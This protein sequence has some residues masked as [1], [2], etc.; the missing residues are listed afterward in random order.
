MTRTIARYWRVAATGIS[1]FVFGLAGLVLGFLV[2]PVMRML[3]ADDR[4][5][6]ARS[7]DLLRY[8]FRGFIALMS[9]LGVIR[10]SV[11]GLERLDRR[12]LLITSNHPSLID[13]VLL[14]AFIHNADCVVDAG[15]VRNRYTRG[16]IQAAGYIPN[17]PAGLPLVEACVASLE[18][19]GN[20]LF[21]A[22]ARRTTPGEPIR[23]T[24]G[25]AQVAVRGSRD[26]TPVTIQCV[27]PHLTR[28]AKW[29][30]VPVRR[31][32]YTITVHEEIAI[33]PF[34][35]AFPEPALSAR[36]LTDHLQLYFS[37]EIPTHAVA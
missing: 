4:R 28:G 31:P 20:V 23:L 2:F 34:L 11:N 10:Y 18:Q 17:Q 32:Q 12:G 3:M 26:V 9:G 22:E 13:A 25:A 16:A 19:G 5:R 1:F 24:R 33:R 7:R 8:A 15:L 21:F 36:A 37:K 6:Q 14:M 29:W 30:R 27:P 35:D